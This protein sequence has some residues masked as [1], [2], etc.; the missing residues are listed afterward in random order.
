M[1]K[2]LAMMLVV[3]MAVTMMAG[4][5]GSS[6]GKSSGGKYDQVVYAFATFNNIPS[7]EAL[8]GVEEAIN[9]ITREK[10]GAEITL[11]P[12]SIAEYS[13]SVTLS[14]QGGEKIDIMQTLF[15][16]FDSHGEDALMAPHDIEDL[17]NRIDYDL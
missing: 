2:V 10:I 3:A 13:Q 1:K 14:L 6:D 9:E 17:R 4:C 11:K 5:G 7:E 8:D 12:I 16:A 15:K